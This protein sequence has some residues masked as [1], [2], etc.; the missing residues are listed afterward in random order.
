MSWGPSPAASPHPLREEGK[1]HTSVLPGLQVLQSRA[2]SCHG[3]IP[4]PSSSFQSKLTWFSLYLLYRMLPSSVLVLGLGSAAVP[5]I[6]AGRA[7]CLQVSSQG[8]PE[9]KAALSVS[10]SP[11]PCSGEVFWLGCV[12]LIGNPAHLSA[13]SPKAAAGLKGGCSSHAPHSTF[14]AKT[15]GERE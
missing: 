5:S 7:G 11:T 3:E 9:M 4:L 10:Y 1:K 13:P 8:S 2:G 6:G 14:P 12:G 15:G